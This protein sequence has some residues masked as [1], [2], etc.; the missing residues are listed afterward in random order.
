MQPKLTFWLQGVK[1]VMQQ[2][3]L[4]TKRLAV[5]LEILTRRNAYE[6]DRSKRVFLQFDPS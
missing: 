6:G 4:E 5:K 2:M 1:K 3:K